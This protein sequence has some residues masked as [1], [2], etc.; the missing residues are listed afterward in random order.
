MIILFAICAFGCS[1]LHAK[2]DETS[3]EGGD[4][5]TTAANTTN[6]TADQGGGGDGGAD[7]A[8]GAGGVVDTTT[9]T[10][11]D[12]STTT[13]TDTS[14]V[15]DMGTTTNTVT[16]SGTTTSTTTD[17]NTGT[18]TS[19]DTNTGTAT[20]TGT[21][22]STTTASPVGK[23]M[24][25]VVTLD[26]TASFPMQLQGQGN[27]WGLVLNQSTTPDS[28]GAASFKSARFE[29]DVAAGSTFVFNGLTNVGQANASWWCVNN[30]QR[31]LI[32]GAFWNPDA[33]N[34]N[35][36]YVPATVATDPNGAGCNLK[37]VAAPAATPADDADGDGYKAN[38]AIQ[39]DKDCDDLNPLAH[40]GQL[41]TWGDEVDFDCKGQANPPLWKYTVSGGLIVGKVRVQLVDANSWSNQL[42]YFATVRPMIRNPAISA[43]Q[44]IVGSWESPKN[45]AVRYKV[46]AADANWLWTPYL[47]GG[48]CQS[49]GV[50]FQVSESE[51]GTVVPFTMTLADQC[52]LHKQ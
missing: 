7:A 11:T 49:D 34:V 41:E 1:R 17:T 45:Y 50:T 8:G 37:V 25:V 12:T 29:V 5:S 3:G 16:D 23:V 4:G 24:I 28:I 31:T 40:P 42:N 21:T 35:S 27:D 18:T 36:K 6:D 32:V 13:D 22:S 15:T 30:Q 48:V 52:H 20:D 10:N 44:D 39:T 38:A 14:T 47:W 43:F 9:A 19:T 33:N 51:Y 26:Q 2:H 46:N